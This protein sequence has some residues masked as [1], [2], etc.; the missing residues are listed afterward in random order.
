M[1]EFR[2]RKGSNFNV[3][4]NDIHCSDPLYC[5]SG[6]G[7]CPVQMY[8]YVS[9]PF[10]PTITIHPIPKKYCRWTNDKALICGNGGLIGTPSVMKREN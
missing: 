10:C 9:L 5:K 6:N 1:E 8:R 3:V 2:G 4:Y 7:L